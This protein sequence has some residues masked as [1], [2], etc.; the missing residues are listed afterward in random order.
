MLI[1][2]LHGGQVSVSRFGIDGLIILQ[3]AGNVVF[4]GLVGWR[5]V[6]VF[7]KEN[8]GLAHGIRQSRQNWAQVAADADTCAAF[9]LEPAFRPIEQFRTNALSLCRWLDSNRTHPTERNG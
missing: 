6:T 7:L 4:V 2:G 5:L 9:F 1:A 3:A 8:C